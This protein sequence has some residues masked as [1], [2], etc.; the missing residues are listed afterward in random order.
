[1][2]SGTQLTETANAGRGESLTPQGQAGYKIYED[3]TCFCV[4]MLGLDKYRSIALA[5]SDKLLGLEWASPPVQGFWR[6]FGEKNMLYSDNWKWEIESKKKKD[7][8]KNKSIFK[9]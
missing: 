7:N 2:F 5:S 1:M 3:G 4:H 9:K 6:R 8:N